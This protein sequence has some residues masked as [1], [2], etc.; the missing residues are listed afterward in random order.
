M[1]GDGG[2]PGIIPRTLAKIFSGTT[3]GK[4]KR[5]MTGR[6]SYY[7]IYNEVINDLLDGSKKNLDIREDKDS[8][9]FVKDLTQVEVHDFK[10][11][12]GYL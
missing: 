11:A 7:E 4:S 9:V 1:K 6:M 5:S 12:M 2:D 8:G 10:S 3:E